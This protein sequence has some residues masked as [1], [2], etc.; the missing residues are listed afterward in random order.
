MLGPE[1]GL[2]GSDGTVDDFV[3]AGGVQAFIS[4]TVERLFVAPECGDAV[5][6]VRVV[7]LA[8]AGTGTG[9]GTALAPPPLPLPFT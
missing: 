4:G 3:T 1:S 2:L 8:L 5:C 7:A 9:A 6:E